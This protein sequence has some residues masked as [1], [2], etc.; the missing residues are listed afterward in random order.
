MGESVG[1]ITSTAIVNRM[2]TGADGNWAICMV[3]GLGTRQR[4]NGRLCVLFLPMTLSQ[5]LPAPI[6]NPIFPLP[7]TPRRAGWDLIISRFPTI[8]DRDRG[9]VHRCSFTTT[10]TPGPSF[11]SV[12]ILAG[13]ILCAALAGNP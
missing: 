9:T 7:F 8:A 11:M 6:P 2:E 3:S 5:S 13:M 4:S 1:G 10:P 12:S